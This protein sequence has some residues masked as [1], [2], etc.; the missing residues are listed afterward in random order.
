MRDLI[1]ALNRAHRLD[2]AMYKKCIS[3]DFQQ[4]GSYP[5]MYVSED[6]EVDYSEEIFNKYNWDEMFDRWKANPRSVPKELWLRSK[7]VITKEDGWY[8]VSYGGLDDYEEFDSLASCKKHVASQYDIF[9]WTRATKSQPTSSKSQSQVVP[10]SYPEVKP[11]DERKFEYD[12]K[13][14]CIFDGSVSFSYKDQFEYIVVKDGVEKIRDYEFLHLSKLKHVE[15][16]DS[17]T[18]I[19]RAAFSHCPNLISIEVPN[20]VTY[21]GHHA[22]AECENLRSVTIPDS[23]PYIGSD[24]F[25]LCPNLTVTCSEESLAHKQALE[26]RVSVNLI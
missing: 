1:E 11:K 16:P 4:V 15:I 9:K 3:E 18:S 25:R 24:A 19:G 22:F 7:A 26:D 14:R 13:G 2:E 10:D 12:D 23:V 5:Y 17:V 20:S 6:P 21:I 8:Q